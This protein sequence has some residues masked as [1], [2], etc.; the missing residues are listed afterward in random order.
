MGR[1]G[2]AGDRTVTGRTAVTALP[3]VWHD[4]PRLRRIWRW[5]RP[6]RFVTRHSPVVR[7]RWFLARTL[8]LPHFPE[9]GRFTLSYRDGT[10]VELDYG[11][12]LGRNVLL[13]GRFEQ[14]EREWLAARAAGGVAV[15]VGANVG[16]HT[17]A[18]AAAGARVIAVEPLRDNVVRLR[19]TVAGHPG[20]VVEET[21]LGDR[22]GTV[23]YGNAADGALAGVCAE[24]GAGRA[25][26]GAR[27]AEGTWEMTTLDALWCRHGSPPVRVVKVDVEGYEREVL[28]GGR[29][30]LTTARPD[31]LVESHEPR[32]ITGL[33]A[34]VG[35]RR[36][37]RP[38]GFE[39]W[40]H[41][42][43]PS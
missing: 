10:T 38:A 18:M 17:A 1:P 22:E 21:A 14:A 8:V 4:D 33:L 2:A 31:L 37:R 13:S 15:D 25:G 20:V 41:V 9:N 30:L 16:L 3:E 6:L 11:E 5:G 43:V 36:A 34:G 7:G 35:Y 24:D 32:R 26:G 27:H 19:R 23:H 42:F 40:N 39:P 29:Q 12:A 28:A